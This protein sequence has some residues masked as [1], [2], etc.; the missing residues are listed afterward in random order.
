MSI[1]ETYKKYSQIEHVLARP[2]MYIGDISTETSEQWILNNDG[3][4]IISKFVKW[5]PGIYKIFD[6]IITNCS[7]E[8]QRSELVKNIVI[9]INE[10]TIS[11]YN[12][13]SG[14]PIELHKEHNIYVPELIFGNLLSSSNYNDSKKKNYRWIKW[15]R[16]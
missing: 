8:C 16:C 3:D 12:D 6:E 1:E 4:K 2:G 13:G 15:V 10:N 5:N 11:I 7:D 14:I 9:T